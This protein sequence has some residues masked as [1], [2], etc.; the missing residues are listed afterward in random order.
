MLKH[1][2]AVIVLSSLSILFLVIGFS[3]GIIVGEDGKITLDKPTIDEEEVISR[4]QSETGTVYEMKY[5]YTDEGEF[6]GF[7][8]RTPNEE[9]DQWMFLGT[10]KYPGIF[11]ED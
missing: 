2:K 4:T 8:A 10:E 5:L 3:L 6:V 11:Q 1:E 7:I 9:G